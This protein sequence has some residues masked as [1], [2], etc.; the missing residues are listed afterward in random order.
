MLFAILRLFHAYGPL[1]FALGFLMPLCAQLLSASGTPLP[2]GM[3]PLL[4]G[5]LI[6]G[7]LGIPAQLRG[8]WI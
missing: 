6:A 3:S 8:R 5:L 4:A 7:A 1:V 2:F